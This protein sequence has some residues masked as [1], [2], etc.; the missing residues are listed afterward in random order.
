MR[1]VKRFFYFTV[2][3]I[4]V[5]AVTVIVVLQLWQKNHPPVT[6]DTTPVVIMITPTQSINLPLMSNNSGVDG[7]LPV[8][9]GI[10]ITQ[11]YQLTPSP[12]MLTYQVK[13]GDT[14]GALAVEFNVMV[15]DILAV[16]NLADP[17]SITIG[18]IL[19]IPT[20]PLP[21]A[22]STA[23][24]PTMVASATFHPSATATQ[25]PI[26]TAT[27]TAAGQQAQMV[28]AAVVGAG[29]LETERVQLIRT[30]DGELSLDGWRLE[31]G[32]G[33]VYIFPDLTLYKGGTINVNTRNGQDTV[34]DLFWGLASPIWQPGKTV[35]L[36]DD[37]D[38]LRASYEIP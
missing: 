11:T 36:Y 13:E 18:Q 26:Y 20:A 4:I 6:V 15:G 8:E 27:A 30:G 21:E 17:D 37:Q 28:I 7:M 14:I 33:K 1:Q 9:A 22:T 24:P 3:N 10:P 32:K 38:V 29:D 16:N 12:E 2:L 35:S 23:I 19:Y 5:S 31:D 25:K 34:Q